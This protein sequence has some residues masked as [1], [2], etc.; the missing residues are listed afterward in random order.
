[1]RLLYLYHEYVM[2]FVIS[3]TLVASRGATVMFVMFIYVSLVC[4]I[5][6]LLEFVCWLW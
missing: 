3:L 5:P 1:M 4:Y 2:K 6:H